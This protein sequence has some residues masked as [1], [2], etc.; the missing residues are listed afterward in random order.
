MGDTPRILGAPALY[1][2]G[3]DASSRIGDIA[4]G[5]GRNV[6]FVSD[7]AVERLFAPRVRQSIEAS[8][9]AFSSVS[10]TGD[11]TPA[12]VERMAGAQR[13]WQ[14]E[15]VIAAGGGKG[16]DAGKA[17]ACALGTRLITLPTAPSNDGPTSRVYLLYDE[18]HRLLSVEKLPRNPDAVVVDTAILAAAPVD[19]LVSGIGDAIV[20]RYEAAQCI[21]AAGLNLFGGQ[22]T[23]LAAKLAET[24][25]EIVR[26]HAVAGLASARAR[27]PNAA[28]EA[29]VEACILLAG[30]GFEGTGLSVAHSMTRGLTAVPE[31]AG[32]LHGRQVAYA[33][34]VQFVLEK[35]SD[36]FMAEQFDFYR[37]VGLPTGLP[38]LGLAAPSARQLSTIAAHTLTAPHIRNFERRLSEGDLVEAMVRLEQLC[39]AA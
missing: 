19:L 36:A 1:V 23:L 10:F 31:T 24:C 12:S 21:G 2:Q 35:R 39:V 17:V 34:L 8:G 25:D 27:A 38:E 9:L 5:L 11:L 28:F 15:V 14:P 7:A 22:A 37:A 29:L 18:H 20:K 3:P 30:I 26:R 13:A 4:A 16:V 33:L 32:A 6:L